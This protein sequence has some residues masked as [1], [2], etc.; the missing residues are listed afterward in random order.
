M[1]EQPQ[2]HADAGRKG[3]SSR[4]D[5]KRASSAANLAKARVNRWKGRELAQKLTQ[6]ARAEIA[7]IK[8]EADASGI[9]RASA[10]TRAAEANL[11]A[12]EDC[13][14]KGDRIGMQ[15][16]LVLAAVNLATASWNSGNR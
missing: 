9:P 13:A 11:Q 12:A 8:Q 4:S 14:V 10:C 3:G 5:R 15:D 6:E 1:S 2:H 16:N 7:K